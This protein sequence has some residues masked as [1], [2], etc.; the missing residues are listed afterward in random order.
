MLRRLSRSALIAASAVLASGIAPA[1]AAA[2][3]GYQN[4]TNSAVCGY[5]QAALTGTVLSVRLQNLDNTIGSGLYSARI[6]FANVIGSNFGFNTAFGAAPVASSSGATQFGNTFPTPGAG[7]SYDGLGGFNFLDLASFYNVVIE[8][9]MPSAYHS[10]S[11]S[12]PGGAGASYV[13]FDVDLA[14][15]QGIS[16]NTITDLGFTTDYGEAIGAAVVATPEPSSLAL[17]GTGLLGIGF[18][19]SRR[20]RTNA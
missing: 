19:A 14:Q 4:C 11:F 20:R 7:W 17:L 2:Q 9:S 6:V 1:S 18:R 16:G 13:Q 15:V 10:D 12:T 3:V 8:G 5:V